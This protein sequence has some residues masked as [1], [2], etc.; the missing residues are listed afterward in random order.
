M[1]IRG[2]HKFF[3]FILILILPLA[4]SETAWARLEPSLLDQARKAR[5]T[6]FDRDAEAFVQ[7]VTFS[8]LQSQ[9]HAKIPGRFEPFLEA[10]FSLLS[11]SD[12]RLFQYTDSQHSPASFQSVYGKAG[13]GLPFGLMVEAG[14]SQVVS[15]HTLTGLYFSF[16]GQVMDL[17]SVVYTDIVPCMSLN[18]NLMR[19]VAVPT[20][21]SLGGDLALGIYHRQ[22]LTQVA[23][24]LQ[25]E[26]SMLG[27]VSGVDKFFLRHGAVLSAP[28]YKGLSFKTE[29]FLPVLSASLGLT[30]QF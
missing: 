21:N 29:I 1:E 17:V 24:A 25:A 26:Y 6:D 2:I 11:V 13:I 9:N 3:F 19:S 28:V 7:A 20:M 10:G 8:L 4:W 30:Y 15:E 12:R 14:I 18:M 5:G 27:A 23:Y 22:T 16:G